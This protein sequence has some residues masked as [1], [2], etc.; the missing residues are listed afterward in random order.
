MTLLEVVG[1]VVMLAVITAGVFQAVGFVLN[2]SA[3]EQERLGAVGLANRLVLLYLDDEDHMPSPSLPLDY[4]QYQYR[5]TL[6]VDPV[7]LREAVK[8][9]AEAQSIQSPV[10]I[11]RFKQVTVRVV[12]SRGP[13]WGGNL[14]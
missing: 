4:E 14:V 1:A 13:G 6:T 2:A 10:G 9:K 5:W 8:P 11:D 3:R 12:L 7:R